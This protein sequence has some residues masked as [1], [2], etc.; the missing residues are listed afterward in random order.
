MT[1]APEL[2]AIIATLATDL[3]AA[4]AQKSPAALAALE[5]RR[6]QLLAHHLGFAPGR[7]IDP[8]FVVG[9]SHVLFFGGEN[10]LNQI[11]HSHV[12]F[13]RP[14]HITRGLDLLP[15]FHTRHLGP[16]TAWRAVESGSS[17]RAREK[18]DALVRRELF[19]GKRV[20]LSFGEID[21]R[22]H[23]PKVV[24]AGS[25]PR[26]AV[27]ETVER[28]LQLARHLQSR[29]VR[30]AMWGPAMVM[31]RAEIRANNPLAGIGSFALRTE[32]VHAY[33]D[34]L[35]EKCA[36]LQLPCVTLAGT[37]HPW[38]QPADPEFFC[39]G[40]HLSQRLMPQ[41][42]KALL[43]SGALA[44]QTSTAVPPGSNPN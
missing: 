31:A 42:L 37:Y 1:A 29:G 36:A 16:A 24:L 6:H 41:A 2:D 15:C 19:P 12:G 38:S 17:T 32:I 22:C 5:E 11:K 18:I 43:D 25:S 4:L 40:F 13:W 7:P 28:S 34:L 8:V 35:H 20:L 14:H 39:D 21:C 30:V 33:C 23:I 9:D 27:R 3:K 10:G 44:L 26:D